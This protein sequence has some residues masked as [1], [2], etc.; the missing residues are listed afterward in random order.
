M[1]R[2][3]G[4]ADPPELA[5]RMLMQPAGLGTF[6]GAC[7]A[8]GF[9]GLVAALLEDPGYEL[10]DP[11]TRLV[12]RL[13]LAHDVALIAQALG[14]PRPAIADLDA[15]A[16]INVSSDEPL[17]RSLHRLG[18]VSLEPEVADD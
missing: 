6:H 17:I 5:L 13:R 15:P 3:V 11:E 18:F 1:Y 7:E 16:T 14:R 8:D 9:R 10:A 4:P 2:F 12:H